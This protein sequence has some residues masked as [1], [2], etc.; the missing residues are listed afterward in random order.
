LKVLIVWWLTCVIWSTVWLAIKLG[1]TDV[2]PFGFAASRLAIAI[3][4]LAI[5]VIARRRPLPLK[6]CDLVLIGGSGVLVLG[7]NYA[8]LYWGAQYISSGL[9]AVLQATTPLFALLIGHYVLKDD[10]ITASRVAALALGIAGVVLIFWN[11]T[12]LAEYREAAGALAVV[13]SAASVACGYAIVGRYLKHVDATV[14][15][16]G[17]MT[18]AL[19]P[20]LALAL[21]FEGNPLTFRWTGA[22]IASLLYLVFAG[23]I[24]AL[25]MNYWL[26]R[27]MTTTNVLMMA[28]VEPMLATIIGAIVLHESLAALAILGSACILLSATLALRARSSTA[29]VLQSQS[30][31]SNG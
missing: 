12:H 26:L 11:Q 13:I 22:A 14:V 31:Q 17:Q 25:W 7:F 24:A 19:V 3:A 23:S 18:S 9:S 1:V 6:R 27:H 21:I 20:L 4:V 29:G 28:I 2:P 15:M 16:A 30:R 5:I 10:R 8:F